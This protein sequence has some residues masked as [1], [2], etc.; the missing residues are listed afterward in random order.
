MQFLEIRCLNCSKLLKIVD[1]ASKGERITICGFCESCGRYCLFY[2][3]QCE[4][5]TKVFFEGQ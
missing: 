5:E 1:W 4:A 3:D 2:Y